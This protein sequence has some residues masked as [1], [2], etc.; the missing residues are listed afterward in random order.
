MERHWGNGLIDGAEAQA[1]LDS[2]PF[3]KPGGKPK[4]DFLRRGDRACR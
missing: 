4:I 1:M 3:T 2:T